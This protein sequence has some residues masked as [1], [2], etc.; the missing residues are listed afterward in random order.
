MDELEARIAELQA[1]EELAR[2][3]PALDGNQVMTYLGLPP[4]PLVGEALAH[5]LELRLDEGP[6]PEDEAYKRLSEWARDR[7]VE[8]GGPP[9]A[10]QSG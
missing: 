10:D 9:G 5:L 6:I 8:P 2:I 1:R 7:G 3:R 4:G